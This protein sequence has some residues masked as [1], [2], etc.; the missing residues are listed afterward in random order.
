MCTVASLNPYVVSAAPAPDAASGGADAATHVGAFF[1]SWR[2]PSVSMLWA[3]LRHFGPGTTKEQDFDSSDV[4]VKGKHQGNMGGYYYDEKGEITGQPA[5]YKARVISKTHNSAKQLTRLHILLIEKSTGGAF[6]R[7]DH[8]LYDLSDFR[9]WRFSTKAI[10]SDEVNY[11]E[12]KKHLEWSRDHNVK[13][14]GPVVQT[15]AH[16][17]ENRVMLMADMSTI[18]YNTAVLG[19]TRFDASSGENPYVVSG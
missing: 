12:H 1:D 15:E 8:T 11:E 5:I 10:S 18:V 6:T 4:Y 17:G 3:S 13:R 14:H 9:N 16:S 7:Y 19:P 2:T